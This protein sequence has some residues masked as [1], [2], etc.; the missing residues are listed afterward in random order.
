VN[1]HTQT[2]DLG[3]ADRKHTE[4]LYSITLDQMRS[5]LV[6]PNRSSFTCSRKYCSF[7]DQCEED[8]G[9]EVE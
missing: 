7:A 9:G 2:V 3:E 8:Y 5:G 6:K 1:L 4:R